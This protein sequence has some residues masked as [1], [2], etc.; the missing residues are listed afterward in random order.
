[1]KK[2]RQ[3]STSKGTNGDSDELSHRLGE[4]VRRLRGDLKLSIRALA[5]KAELSSGLICELEQ[6]RVK[7]TV[8]T[9][10]KLSDALGVRPDLFLGAVAGRG[11]LGAEVRAGDEGDGEEIGERWE[12]LRRSNRSSM[13]L[14]NGLHWEGLLPGVT[15]TC[16]FVQLTLPPGG[17]ADD[18][19]LTHVG[20][21]FGLVLAGRLMVELRDQCHQLDA[22]D[23]IYFD[24]SIPHRLTNPGPEVLSVL[25]VNFGAGATEAGG[26]AFNFSNNERQPK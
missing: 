22:G 21:E 24:S 6:G 12:I 18:Q 10:L 17:T 15:P 23:C 8:R 13:T 7:P 4:L 2:A 1:M 16:S 3:Q 9:L 26:G 14:D 11:A 5:A 25:W 19:I 20:S